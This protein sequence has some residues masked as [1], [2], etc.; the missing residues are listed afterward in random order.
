MEAEEVLQEEVEA[1]L[2]DVEEEYKQ[3]VL[4]V[5]EGVEVEHIDQRGVN[6]EKFG[7]HLR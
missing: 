2:E 6:H 5:V 4:L 1:V 7:R 3:T